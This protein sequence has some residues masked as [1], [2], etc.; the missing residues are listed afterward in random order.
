MGQQR[1]ICLILLSRVNINGNG[2]TKL[3][4]ET[5]IIIKDKTNSMT[6]LIMIKIKTIR[7][8][9]FTSFAANLTIL[10]ILKRL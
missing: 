7:L 9:C 2:H 1:S 10:K 3:I 4:K 6:S 5:R 8:R